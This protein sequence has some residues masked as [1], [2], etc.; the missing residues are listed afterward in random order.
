MS[1]TTD[2]I[3]ETQASPGIPPTLGQPQTRLEI[4]DPPPPESDT[5]IYPSGL[6]LWLALSS[7]L[8]VALAKGLVSP[9]IHLPL[10]YLNLTSIG[11]YD[12]GSDCAEFDR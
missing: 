11:H 10:E 6:K 2:I 4:E 7:V 9:T 8:M 1:T 12:R 3:T 5:T